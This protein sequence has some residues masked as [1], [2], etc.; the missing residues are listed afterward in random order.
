MGRTDKVHTVT[1]LAVV[2]IASVEGAVVEA[3]EVRVVTIAVRSRPVEAEGT[4]VIDIRPVAA[5]CSR[6]EDC[7]MLF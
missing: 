2:Q 7:A 1:V 6:Q 3:H 5:A 4:D